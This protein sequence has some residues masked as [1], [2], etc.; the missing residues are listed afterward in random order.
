MPADD[1]GGCQLVE[2]VGQHVRADPGQVV[3]QVAVSLGAQD[4]LTNDEQS[5]PF[6]HQVQGMSHPAGVLI[7]PV[8]GHGQSPAVLL[9]LCK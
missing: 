9:P 7:A 1:S 2:P 8:G 6:T 4:E 5:P 3:L